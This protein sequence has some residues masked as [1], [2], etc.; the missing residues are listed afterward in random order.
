MT[1]VN[2]GRL[3]TIDDVLAKRRDSNNPV[4]SSLLDSPKKFEANYKYKLRQKLSIDSGLQSVMSCGWNEEGDL[5][6]VVGDEGHVT[7]YTR[8]GN[9][10]Y[11]MRPNSS[12]LPTTCLKWRPTSNS[13]GSLQVLVTVD[14]TGQIVHWHVPTQKE[15]F[16]LQE[17]DNQIYSVQY[18]QDGEQFATTGRDCCVRVYDEKTKSNITTL[19]KGE[20][21]SVGHS[22]RVF[23]SAFHPENPNVLVSGGWDNTLVLWDL[24]EGRSTTTIYGPFLAGQSLDIQNDVIL[25]G[26]WRSKDALEAWD[27][28]T[29]KKIR[30]IGKETIP[31]VYTASFQGTTEGLFFAGGASESVAANTLRLYSIEGGE[32][33]NAVQLDNRRGIYTAA[34]NR[35]NEIAVAGNCNRVGIF[36]M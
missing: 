22:N 28:K 26:S 12:G 18:R 21:M 32:V 36:A 23:A 6:G 27:L 14:V 25:T 8:Q 10:V 29:L 9:P 3:P 2:Y 16:R 13:L 31:K 24:R 19:S 30:N 20:N 11:G 17:E 1:T 15:I 7:V 35:H 34:I 4:G 5:L 33:S